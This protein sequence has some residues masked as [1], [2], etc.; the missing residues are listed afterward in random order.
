MQRL[1]FFI[2]PS[3]RGHLDLL[4]RLSRSLAHGPLRE[5]VEKCALDDEILKV[6]EAGDAAAAETKS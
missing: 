1:F 2:A 5:L 3:P 4:A 6:I